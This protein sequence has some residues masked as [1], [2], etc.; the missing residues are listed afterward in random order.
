MVGCGAA[1]ALLWPL[2]LRGALSAGRACP[3]LSQLC[4]SD[5][6]ALLFWPSHSPVPVDLS[7]LH[8]YGSAFSTCRGHVFPFVLCLSE[9]NFLGVEYLPTCSTSTDH[10]GNL[11]RE[12]FQGPPQCLLLETGPDCLFLYAG[13]ALTS[14]TLKPSSLVFPFSCRKALIGSGANTK[15]WKCRIET[16]SG[17]AGVMVPRNT[18]MGLF[19][20][21]H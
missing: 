9:V 13:C 15:G 3:C 20:S 10:T 19:H 14:A 12:V 6:P 2:G 8:P 21:Q 4:R 17:I 18:T 16:A 7:V 1:Q 11:I 5:S